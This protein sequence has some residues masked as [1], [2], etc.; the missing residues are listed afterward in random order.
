MAAF[1]ALE[2]VSK[3]HGEGGGSAAPDDDVDLTINAGEFV[4]IMGLPDPENPPP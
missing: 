4:A 1:L 3:T 2:N